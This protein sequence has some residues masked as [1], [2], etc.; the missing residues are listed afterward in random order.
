MKIYDE[1]EQGTDEWFKLRAGRFT[2]STDMQQLVT[3]KKDTYS[4]LIIKKASEK[5]TGQLVTSNYTN[6]NMERGNEL[7]A[8]A[9]EA[10][11]LETGLVIDRVGF[12][13]LD[14]WAGCSPD[15]LIGKDSGI[16]IKCKDIHTHLNCFI[17]G[18]DS[19]YKWQIQGAMMVTGRL[20]WFFVSYNPYYAHLG[21]H[22]FI[23][24]IDRDNE[25]IAQIKK[26]IENGVRDVKEII[27][28]IEVTK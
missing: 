4:K 27:K 22:L 19:S 6:S 14:E 28:K 11:Q 17:D 13:E 20:S 12:V 15:G 2:A 9:V 8:Q 1:I 3:G 5:I 24:K 26:G 7:E 18:W 25:M 23:K 21:K 16:E 10:F